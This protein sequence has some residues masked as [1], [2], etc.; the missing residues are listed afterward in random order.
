MPEKALLNIKNIYKAFGMNAVLKGI[1]LD[2]NEGEVLALIGGNGAGK[3]TLMKIIMGIYQ[4]DRGE[5]YVRGE[6]VTSNKTSAALA[7]GIYMVPQEP[8]LF[9]NMSVEE[10]IVI[11]FNKKN[12]EL[13]KDL[14]D[15]MKEVG[16]KLDLGRK[17][18]S[19]SIA[20]QQMVEILRGLLR[21]A[22]IL[23]LDEPT[24]A[25]T[26]DEVESLFKSVNELKAKGIGIIYITHRLAEVFEIATDVA[27]MRDGRIPVR[28]KVSEFTREMLV[29]GLL[30]PD[31]QEKENTLKQQMGK[32]DYDHAKPV[33]ELQHYSGYG[34]T[35]I[36]LKVYPGEILGLAGV[37]GA[38]RTEL[39]TTVFGRDKVLSGKAILDGKDITGLS[40]KKVIEAG[41]NYVPEDRH[42]HGLF[43]ISDIA[44]NTSSAMLGE[45]PM[46][47]FLL[48]KKEEYT[49][50]Q[51]YIDN[52]RTKVTGQNQLAGS[53]SGGNQQKVVIGRSLSTSPKLLILDEPTRG[54]DAAARGDV[55]SI[56]HELRNEG[57]SVLLISS[58][59]EEIVELSDRVMTVCQGRINGEFTGDEI[60]QDSL[61]AAAFGITEDSEVKA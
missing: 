21:H 34:F 57:V 32:I 24:S 28:G 56:I 19:L 4:H 60:N 54:I 8:M 3:S 45:K 20:E 17:A 22:Q 14:V 43:K 31:A 38:G 49:M 16:W 2:L 33:F 44:A 26:F 7:S 6:K 13:H 55:Y 58:D 41:L 42:L 39:A 37:V 9:P 59:M 30:P 47:K 53:L 51:K 46:G 36:S 11:G 40:T 12:S 15:L 18:S 10:N 52:F 23:I 1:S 50:T 25:L 27:I 61:M 29:K 5:I 48:N 35:D